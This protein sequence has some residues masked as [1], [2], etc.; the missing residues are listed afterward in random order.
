MQFHELICDLHH[1]IVVFP[2]LCE[3]G[4]RQFVSSKAKQ[5]M[6]EERLATRENCYY[7]ERPVVPSHTIFPVLL[8]V[9]IIVEHMR[10]AAT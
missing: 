8:P 3:D 6:Q 7:P 2:V 5:L 10:I 4:A 9:S 1:C